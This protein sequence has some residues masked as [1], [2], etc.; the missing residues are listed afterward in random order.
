M[1][2]VTSPSGREKRGTASARK[3]IARQQEEPQANQQSHTDAP[4]P[5]PRPTRAKRA[6]PIA[7]SET[8]AKSSVSS[9]QTI[10]ATTTKAGDGEGRRRSK[11]LRRDFAEDHSIDA[12]TNNDQDPPMTARV[13]R[14]Q[15]DKKARNL[16]QDQ[17]VVNKPP[18]NAYR[19]STCS[20][21]QKFNGA[22]TQSG[23]APGKPQVIAKLSGRRMAKARSD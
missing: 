18:A 1:N 5:S 7:H 17:G 12:R 4:I 19:K 9:Q 20:E 3:P 15:S 16:F 8:V 21:E 23:K 14:H 22:T 11:R 6:L 2:P 13:K 10:S